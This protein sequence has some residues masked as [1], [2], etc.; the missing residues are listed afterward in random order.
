MLKIFEGQE[1]QGHMYIGGVGLVPAIHREPVVHVRGSH[2]PAQTG[3]GFC[4]HPFIQ[5][6][7]KSVK[8]NLTP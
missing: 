8:P 1:F 3:P 2:V 7:D 4:L 5:I 6:S